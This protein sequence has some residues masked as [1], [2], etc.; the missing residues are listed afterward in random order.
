MSGPAQGDAGGRPPL[1]GLWHVALNVVDLESALAFYRDVVGLAV[2]WRPDPDNVYLT[3]GRD[4][5]AIHRV[6][7]V[8]DPGRLDHFGFV[9]PTAAAVDA[10]AEH[11]RARGHALAQAP[12]THRDGARSFYVRDPQGNLVQ[13]IHH[14]PLEIAARRAAGEPR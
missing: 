3:S 8:V 7:R 14:P 13:F 12:K 9:V 4:N 6:E 10:W 1:G 2:E 11:I 5:L